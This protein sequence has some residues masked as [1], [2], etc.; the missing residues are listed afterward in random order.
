MHIPQITFLL[1]TMVI[2]PV[3]IVVAARA[4]QLG[5]QEKELKHEIEHD[6][7]E[8]K[9]E[10]KLE[11]QRQIVEEDKH[12]NLAKQNK[13]AV[14]SIS[15][16]LKEMD[17]TCSTDLGPG[18]RNVGENNCFINV[19]VQVGV[20]FKEFSFFGGLEASF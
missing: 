17:V 6:V 4:D 20:L 10:E 9:L 16:E 5:L 2:I 12:R 8:R 13:H 15:E 18:L 7:E 1:A 19:I 3:L 11:Y 14:A